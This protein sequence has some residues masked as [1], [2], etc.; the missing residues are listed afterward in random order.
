M[1]RHLLTRGKSYFVAGA[2]LVALLFQS[3]I[4]AGYMPAADGSFSLQICH[5]GFMTQDGAHDAEGHPLGHSHVEY[6]PFGALPGAGPIS[7]FLALLPSWSIASQALAEFTF[8]YPASRLD[9][10][11]SPRGPPLHA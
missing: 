9:R 4:P 1:S 3:M 8:R 10:S 7:H 6:C 11:H 5:S 2:L